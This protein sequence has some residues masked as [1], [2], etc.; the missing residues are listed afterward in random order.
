MTINMSK[1]NKVHAHTKP[2]INGNASL[3]LR[4]QDCA[5]RPWKLTGCT[6]RKEQQ[7]VL[8]HRVVPHHAQTL[9]VH[10]SPEIGAWILR[11]DE[12]LPTSQGLCG[13]EEG[14]PTDQSCCRPMHPM[15]QRNSMPMC[16]R[17]RLPPAQ[18]EALVDRDSYTSL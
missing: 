9:S 6:I 10:R 12:L 18:S 7:C 11:G 4:G 13:Q 14:S 3:T 17:L 16:D 5:C 1:V 8:G 15:R 2:P